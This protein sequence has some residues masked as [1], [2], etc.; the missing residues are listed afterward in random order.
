MI[1]NI[2]LGII[3]GIAEWLPVSSEGL[4]V[5]TK[6]NIFHSHQ[7]LESTIKLALFLHFGTFLAA[8]IYFWGDVK[9]LF[10]TLFSYSSQPSELKQLIN[11]LTLSTLISGLLGFSFIK[12][13]ER[14][15]LQTEH[16][17]KVLTFIV[18]L[19]LLGTA[20]LELR[21]KKGG[22]KK[23]V[24]LKLVDGIILGIVQGF[25]AFPG[26]SRSG[27]TVSALLLRKFDK[28][29]TLKLSFLMSLPI[30]LAGNIILNLHD[31]NWSLTN[32]Y[33]LFFSFIFGLATIH[34]LLKIAE[35]INFGLFVLLFGILTI[36]A[37]IL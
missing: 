18:G 13:L 27:L 20:F 37:A 17:G 14:V 30:V 31:M 6:T 10:K 3:Q 12:L 5:L 22:Y 34:I 4:I 35:K 36:I 8:L 24:N 15:D 2:I 29:T 16:S 11:F 21:A 9:Q 28:A 25:A 19:F 1:E 32:L 26:L 23:I 33:G 7:D